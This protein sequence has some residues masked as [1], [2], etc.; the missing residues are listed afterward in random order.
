MIAC[1]DMGRDLSITQTFEKWRAVCELESFH[2]A[3]AT[4]SNTLVTR[5]VLTAPNLS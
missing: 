5:A 1:A 3:T 2:F 4:V